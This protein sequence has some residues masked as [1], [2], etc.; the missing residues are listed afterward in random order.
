M[1]GR[2]ITGDGIIA[3]RTAELRRI[4]ALMFPPQP[5][6]GNRNQKAKAQAGAGASDD[7]LIARVPTANDGGKFA[8]LWDGRQTRV[9]NRYSEEAASPFRES[10]AE[11]WIHSSRG[12]ISQDTPW[13]R[14]VPRGRDVGE[15]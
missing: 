12:R 7:D 14:R 13:S 2:R 11:R 1:T 9:V 5:K 10:Q 8:T 6:K 15:V 3:E 4:H